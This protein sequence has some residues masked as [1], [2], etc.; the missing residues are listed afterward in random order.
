MLQVGDIEHDVDVG[1]AITGAGFDVT[2][3]GLCIADHGGDLLQHA[4]AVVAEDGE[5][6]RVG[7]GG[8]VI[9]RPLHVNLPFR[10][11][12]Q[13]YYVGTTEPMNRDTLAASDVADDRFTANRV[14]TAGAVDQ[15]VTLSGYANGVVVLV[16]T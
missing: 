2:D 16:A 12:H 10:L 3:V 15:E 4:E 1:L 14:T 8:P 7:T 11:I 13:V 5:L 6:Y 9:V